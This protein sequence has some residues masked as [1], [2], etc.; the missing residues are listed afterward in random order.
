MIFLSSF[1]DTLDLAAS[2]DLAALHFISR[3]NNDYV[4]LAML[5]GEGE[6]DGVGTDASGR[7]WKKKWK[8]F[9]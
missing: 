5:S 7:G 2:T 8:H 3:R 4:C 6:K 9:T 1:V